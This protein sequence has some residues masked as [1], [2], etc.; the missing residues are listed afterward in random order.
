MQPSHIFTRKRLT[1]SFIVIIVGFVCLIGFDKL[2]FR[3]MN[4]NP[5]LDSV[6]TS[7]LA[8]RLSFSQPLQST[9]QVFIDNEIVNDT[10]IDGSTLV[11]SL[12]N[13][14]LIDGQTY[15]LKI[16]HLSSKWFNFKINEINRVFTVEYVE[17]NQLSDEQKKDQVSRSNS[18]Q[19][20]DP[21]LNNQFPLLDN[22]LVYQIE[23]NTTNGTINVF[24]TFYDEVPDYDNGGLSIQLPDDK[25]EEYRKK[26][27]QTI[28]DN[29]GD[30]D[31]Y[32]I[33]YSNNYLNSK[34]SSVLYH[35]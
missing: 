12:E 30:P 27:I 31:K 10:S 20:S 33:T 4:S 9:D 17:Y 6:A 29:N 16:R 18:G 34:Y 11:V 19:I 35:N 7:S 28:R 15:S 2:T 22:S 1:L 23:A 8:L 3:Y 21:F 13:L 25:A 26:A 32:N 14:K 5:A 24:I